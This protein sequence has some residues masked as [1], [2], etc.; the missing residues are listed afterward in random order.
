MEDQSNAILAVEAF[1]LSKML[2]SI[3]RHL[4]TSLYPE[5]DTEF[6]AQCVAPLPG[7]SFS[8]ICAHHQRVYE[9]GFAYS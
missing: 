3:F 7:I 8:D 9:F 4:R 1:H 6:M 2:S 5:N